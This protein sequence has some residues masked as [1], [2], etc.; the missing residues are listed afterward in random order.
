MKQIFLN[1]N[2]NS[3][4]G[5]SEALKAFRA[6]VQ[7]CGT[8]V[9]CIV[10]TSCLPGDGKSTTS[11]G[12]SIALAQ[13]G[14]KVLIV[15]ADLRKSVMLKAYTDALG[16]VGFSEYLSGLSSLEEVKHNTQFGNLD[17]IFCGQYPANPTELL[18]STAFKSFIEEQKKM[19]DY[20]II[21]TPPL[22]LVVDAAVIAS[23]C[24]SV[25]VVF[26]EGKIKT[27]LANNVIKQLEKSGARII[28][29]VINKQSQKRGKYYGYSGKLARK[30]ADGYSAE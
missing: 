12:L 17:I 6:N 29:T 24:D 16:V 28:G 14:K 11:I 13:A 9:H 7:F 15:D 23:A 19:Y 26:A 1:F 2:I 22:G 5:T 20:I 30:Y 21:D 18:S 8:D 4:S 27:G 25:I 10:M 3:T